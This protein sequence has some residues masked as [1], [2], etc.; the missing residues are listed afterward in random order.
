MRTEYRLTPE[1][2]LLDPA[3]ADSPL[4]PNREPGNTEFFARYLKYAFAGELNSNNVPQTQC[5][6]AGTFESIGEPP[7]EQTDFQHVRPQP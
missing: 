2:E 7:R 4:L 1:G 5:T 6:K 3:T